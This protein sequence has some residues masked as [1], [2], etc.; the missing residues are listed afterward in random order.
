MKEYEY[1]FKVESIKP[2]LEY[3][4]EN[5]YKK[6]SEVKQNR[7]VYENKHTNDIIARITKKIV[8]NKETSTFDIKNVGVRDKNLKDS[9]ESIPLLLTDENK[10]IIESIIKTLDFYEAANNYRTRYVYKKNGVK[11]EIDNYIQ[12]KMQVVGIEGNKNEVDKIYNE[13]V[14]KKIGIILNEE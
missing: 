8:D 13:L 6:E 4:I 2:Y 3:C 5:N 10:N 11:F 1:S 7:I 12:P 14:E 9:T